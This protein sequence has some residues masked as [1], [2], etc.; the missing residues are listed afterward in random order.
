MLCST[1]SFHSSE[2]T[3]SDSGNHF[4]VSLPACEK[5]PDRLGT[6]DLLWSELFL[7]RGQ[8]ER[9]F[10]APISVTSRW[11]DQEEVRARIDMQIWVNLRRCCPLRVDVKCRAWKRS[12]QKSMTRGCFSIKHTSQI[13]IYIHHNRQNV[14]VI[15]NTSQT[16]TEQGESEPCKEHLPYVPIMARKARKSL[17]TVKR[18]T[19]Q[20]AHWCGHIRSTRKHLLLRTCVVILLPIWLESAKIWE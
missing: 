15:L 9:C 20:H 3:N 11:R 10:V 7:F 5:M 12:Q 16:V 17:S 6:C 2:N 14:P 1:L 13:S 18:S 19:Q 4:Q 8:T